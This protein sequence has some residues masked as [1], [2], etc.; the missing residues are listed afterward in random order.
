MLE[1]TKNKKIIIEGVTEQGKTF[2]VRPKQTIEKRREELLNASSKI[3][4]KMTVIYQELTEEGIPRFGV[5]KGIRFD[6]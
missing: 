6:C 3:G 2:S 4:K 1:L 5:G